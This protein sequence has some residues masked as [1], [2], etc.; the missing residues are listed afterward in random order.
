MLFLFLEIHLQLH[1]TGQPCLTDRAKYQIWMEHIAKTNTACLHSGLGSWWCST[2]RWEIMTSSTRKITT[3]LLNYYNRSSF[4]RENNPFLKIITDAKL[5]LVTR[6]L[7]YPSAS[8]HNTRTLS[9]DVS[10]WLS[11]KSFLPWDGIYLNWIVTIFRDISRYSLYVYFHW[12]LNTSNSKVKWSD[13]TIMKPM[14][15]SSSTITT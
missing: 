12:E 15:L 10:E 3:Q 5:F 7:D 2:D 9:Y 14:Y 13:C 6:L 4:E 8:G 11:G 1:S